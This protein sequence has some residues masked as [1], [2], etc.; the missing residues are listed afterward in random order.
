MADEIISRAEAKARGLTRY[1]TGKP[2]KFGHIAERAAA[3]GVCLEC[4]QIWRDAKRQ[5][6]PEIFRAQNQAWK[7]RNADKIRATRAAYRA[8][9]PDA[10]RQRDREQ[11]KKH[12]AKRLVRAAEHYRENPEMMR[13]RSRLWNAANPEYSRD[14]SKRWREENPEHAR[15]LW[16]QHKAR[17]RGAPGRHS[18]KDVAEIYA[19]QKGKCALCKVKVGEDYHVDHIQPVAKGGSN[20]RSNLQILCRPCNQSKRDRDPIDHARRLGLL[21]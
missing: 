12:A 14:Y 17:R 15:H 4:A 20:D 6:H 5:A 19:L 16:R 7:A 1:F 9:N 21:L 3:K 10:M 2:C 13:E 8:A 11:Y 18:K